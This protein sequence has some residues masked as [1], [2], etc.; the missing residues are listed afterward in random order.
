[1]KR[2]RLGIAQGADQRLVLHEVLQQ[3][4]GPGE[5]MMTRMHPKRGI[6]DE[7][8]RFELKGI[9]QA[10]VAGGDAAHWGWLMDIWLR[11]EEALCNV[12]VLL[13]CAFLHE[14]LPDIKRIQKNRPR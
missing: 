12:L 6:H 13:V 14:G 11:L 3:A 7:L 1:M 2:H 9:Q 5:K 4:L 10:C 8:E